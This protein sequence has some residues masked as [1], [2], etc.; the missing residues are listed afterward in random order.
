MIG[1]AGWV[2]GVVAGAAGVGGWPST[3]TTCTGMPMC[4]ALG[5][6]SATLIGMR[7]QPC[8]AGCAGTERE[9]W[10]AMPPLK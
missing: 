3:P 8:D 5:N 1:A 6:H 10:T 7:M 4:T 2:T 9:P